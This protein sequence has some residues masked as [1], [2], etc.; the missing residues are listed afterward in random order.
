[1]ESTLLAKAKASPNRL[2][3][4][5][6]ALSW[7]RWPNHSWKSGQEP[8]VD[9]RVI[10]G[11][12]YRMTIEISFPYRILHAICLIRFWH[13]WLS[14]FWHHGWENHHFLMLSLDTSGLTKPAV[15]AAILESVRIRLVTAMVLTKLTMNAASI[16][17]FNQVGLNS[18]ALFKDCSLR[19]FSWYHRP[20]L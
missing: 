5:L 20:V 17:N 4:W 10:M 9:L 13:W 11:G 1:M 2:I 19:L 6:D 7:N 12:Y 3:Y 14:W 15:A 18:L 8:L 16:C